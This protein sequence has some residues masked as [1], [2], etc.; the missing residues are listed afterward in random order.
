[1]LKIVGMGCAYPE[2]V[3]DNGL[4]SGLFG[5][6]FITD[7]QNETGISERRTSLPLSYLTETKNCHVEAVVESGAESPTS[8]G[9]RAAQ[10]A[11]S[12]AEIDSS[13]IGL[14]VA[15]CLTPW[16]TIPAEAT[17]IGKFFS[18]KV[19]A[20]DILGVG[21]GL[22]FL[23]LVRKWRPDRIPEYILFVVTSTPTQRINYSEGAAG[24]YFGDCAVAFIVSTQKRPGLRIVDTDYVVEAP[25]YLSLDMYGH[26]QFNPAEARDV[27]STKSE[28]WIT[29]LNQSGKLV[30]S[31]SYFIGP[32]F[33]GPW[34][35]QLYD[36]YQIK[37]D[38]RLGGVSQY[39]CCLAA[40]GVATLATHFGQMK[41]DDTV[42][43]LEAGPG[44]G[45]G[46][47]LFV[48]D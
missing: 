34:M 12:Q 33:E 14:V 8:L 35:E 36:K 2:G 45:S 18:L 6:N 1:M 38:S 25:S 17:R 44:S 27:I 47:G 13:A 43:L 16:E 39:G 20:Y 26:L 22:F 5:R 28:K 31:N 19:P 41:N 10:L 15:D 32:Q 48:A 29:H 46:Y 40:S 37:S 42:V 7:S 21:S 4:L 9:V 24:Y 23:D 30:S 3:I 11:L